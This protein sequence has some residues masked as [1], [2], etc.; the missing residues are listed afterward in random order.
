MFNCYV[1]DYSSSANPTPICFF[2][3]V[4]T[5][6]KVKV[7]GI[8]LHLEENSA[9]TLEFT[10][11]PQNVA[12]DAMKTMSSIIEVQ[13]DGQPFWRGRILKEERDAYDQ[14]KFSC[15]GGLNFL[16]DT[17]QLPMHI[18]SRIQHWLQ[19]LITTQWHDPDSPEGVY[20]DCHNA[21]YSTSEQYKQVNIKYFDP[22]AELEENVDWYANYESTLELL[23]NAIDAYNL[24]MVVSYENGITNLSFYKDYPL[25]LRSEQTI[26]FGK[27]LISYTRNWELEDLATVIIP[28]GKSYDNEETRPTNP[29]TP[30]EL[31][32]VRTI[33]SVNSGSVML[34]ASSD[35][36][37]RYG[38]I[39]KKVDWNDIEDPAN[40]LDLAQNYFD[41]YQ[42]DKMSIELDMFDLSLMMTGT[43]RDRNELHLMGEVRCVS[44]PHGL[45]RYFP[46]TQVEYDFNDLSKTKFVLGTGDDKSTLSGNVKSS[47]A[48]LKQEINDN[49]ILSMTKIY[50]DIISQSFA[51]ATEYMNSFA[52]VGHVSFMRNPSNPQQVTGIV[53]A[54]KVNWSDSDAHLWMWNQGGLAWSEDGGSTFTGIAITNDGKI[55]ANFITTGILNAGIIQAGV[56]KDIQENIKWNLETGVLNAKDFTLETMSGPD[57]YGYLF[58][59]SDIW[60]NKSVFYDSAGINNVT[61]AGYSSD[62]WKLIVGRFFGVDYDGTASCANLYIGG[63]PSAITHKVVNSAINTPA[64]NP[65]DDDIQLTVDFAVMSNLYPGILEPPLEADSTHLKWRWIFCYDLEVGDQ[66][67][68]NIYGPGYA[69]LATV[70]KQTAYT[71]QALAGTVDFSTKR[72]TK[73]E[74]LECDASHYRIEYYIS[75]DGFLRQNSF[76][77]AGSEGYYDETI[78]SD[79]QRW[80][81]IT[82]RQG[83]LMT[84]SVSNNDIGTG[85]NFFLGSMETGELFG[86]DWK[87]SY[88]IAGTTRSDWMLTVGNSFG[89][90]SS[91]VIYSRDGHFKQAVVDGNINAGSMTVNQLGSNNRYFYFNTSQKMYEATSQTYT[92]NYRVWVES[93]SYHSG[94]TS[95]VV[96]GCWFGQQVPTTGTTVYFYIG[97]WRNAYQST[98]PATGLPC[99]YVEQQYIDAAGGASNY[100]LPTNFFQA[101]TVA[102]S[103]TISPSNQ[104]EV[105]AKSVTVTISGNQNMGSLYEQSKY[106]NNSPCT[107]NQTNWPNSDT[108]SW[109]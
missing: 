14:R 90:T 40:L 79:L 22:N 67:A 64:T 101:S 34:E 83:Y 21:Y 56:L 105:N 27:N 63:F 89:V 32:A 4:S 26:M 28:T 41:T 88:E 38:R 42:F 30:E 53:I 65:Q 59:S 11:G 98:N 91:G 86:S 24:K 94:T 20:H 45:D 9:G 69:T 44:R 8:T 10:M 80:S 78:S 61:V 7:S 102:Q 96:K 107:P 75:Q 17:I 68:D 33:E 47:N 97:R 99:P 5:N 50:N 3:N 66:V 23:A 35:I 55:S 6:P 1:Y 58:L 46:I 108:G 52:N 36:L 77:G 84:G 29:F 49:K 62:S 25:S 54:N 72:F 103:I 15:E 43:E 82:G 100:Y 93:Y 76:Y 12:N 31:D 39:Y 60:K 87:G 73:Q 2:S 74:M 57:T 51:E 104:G 48:S 71:N 95:A 13:K 19:Y 106:S 37:A 109:L 92:S 18:N 81:L 16:A 70:A 85:H